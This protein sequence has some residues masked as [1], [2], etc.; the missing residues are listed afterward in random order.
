MK[1]QEKDKL[2][3]R[4]CECMDVDCPYCH[5]R[6]QKEATRGLHEGRVALCEKCFHNALYEGEKLTVSSILLK[7]GLASPVLSH[8]G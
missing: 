3:G 6:C 1:K 2:G 4:H 7:P 5:G 8:Q